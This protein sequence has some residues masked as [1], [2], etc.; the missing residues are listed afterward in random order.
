MVF[1]KRTVSHGKIRRSAGRP[2]KSS[3]ACARVEM[4]CVFSRCV[5]CSFTTDSFFCLPIPGSLSAGCADT[6]QTPHRI[7]LQTSIA[8]LA[9][10]LLSRFER[11]TSRSAGLTRFR[12]GRESELV[13]KLAPYGIIPGRAFAR[14][15]IISCQIRLRDELRCRGTRP[16][17]GG[18]VLCDGIT[19]TILL[20]IE[21]T[22]SIVTLGGGAIIREV[23]GFCARVSIHHISRIVRVCVIKGLNQIPSVACL[24]VQ[25]N[26]LDSDF[27]HSLCAD[28]IEIDLDCITT[29]GNPSAGC[30]DIVTLCHS[31]KSS[32]RKKYCQYKNQRNNAQTSFF[33]HFTS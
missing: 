14:P 33:H 4:K 15:G 13:K 2:F 11:W 24:F 18:R 3:S 12:A 26:I 17:R 30:R 22:G 21:I 1:A 27:V 5:K 8:H 29:S 23:C 31:S 28:N 32:H 9:D 7:H 25:V 10:L 6:G 20:R 19:A 16:M